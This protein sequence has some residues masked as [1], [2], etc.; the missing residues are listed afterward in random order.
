MLSK[1]DIAY[2]SL[3]IENDPGALEQL[4]ALGISTVPA[5]VVGGRSVLG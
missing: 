5:V 4:Q 1:R 3:D 2:E